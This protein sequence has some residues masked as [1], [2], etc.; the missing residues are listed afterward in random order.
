MKIGIIVGSTRPGRNAEAVAQW[1][2]EN[3]KKHDGAE[4]E[5]VD[6]ADYNVPGWD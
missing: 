1:V 3:A 2:L 4:F 6:I 5:L